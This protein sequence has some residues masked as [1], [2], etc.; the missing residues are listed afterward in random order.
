MIVYYN[1]LAANKKGLEYA[2]KIK[3]LA[4]EKIELRDVRETS[5]EEIL[6]TEG[7]VV[8]CGGDGTISRF[9][10]SVDVIPDDREI[11][12][13]PAGTGNDFLRDI[14][15]DGLIL[16]NPYIK[17]LPTA[18]IKG[19]TYKVIN[20]IGYGVDGYCCEQG[21]IQRA[22]SDKP[23]NYTAIAIKGVLYDFK[24]A[25]AVIIVDGKKYEYKKVWLAPTMNGRYYGGGMCVT[26]NQDR[27]N[28]ERKITV[29]IWHTAGKF[30]T[31]T[32]FSSIFKGEHIKYTDMFETIEGYDV[33][34]R[35]D[36]PTPLQVDGETISNVESYTMRSSAVSKTAEGKQPQ[37][38]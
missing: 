6:K 27:L 2:E 35:F 18:E 7:K 13:F 26:P 3:E 4:D 28:P 29:A 21:D 15:K 23:V 14:G 22:R 5:Y 25:N 37:T 19:K 30:K 11:Y 16:L 31:L 36:R 17:D 32:R 12:Y 9:V 34:V 24:P 1:P 38:V 33:E 20:G 10:N 8:L